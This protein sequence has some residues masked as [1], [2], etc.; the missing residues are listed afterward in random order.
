MMDIIEATR[1][2][3]A[4]IQQDARFIRFAKA[5]LQNDN[6]EELQKNIGEFNLTR[7]EM[8]RLAAAEEQDEE[9]MR[10][11]NEKLRAVYTA[12]MASAGMTEYNNAKAELDGLLNDVNSMIMQCVDGADP[13]VVEPEKH[14][15][16][17]SCESCGGCH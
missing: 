11:L 8:D 10:Q 13:A 6:D 17:G 1:N 12:V 9:K 2:L 3:G 4:V 15:C 14:S 16:T 7:M 5:K